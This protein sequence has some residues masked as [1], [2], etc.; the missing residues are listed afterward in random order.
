MMTAIGVLQAL[1]KK[2]TIVHK[3][4]LIRKSLKELKEY[5]YITTKTNT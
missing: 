3:R 2:K 5:I 4:S 1:F